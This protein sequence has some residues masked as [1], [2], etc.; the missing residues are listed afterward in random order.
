MISASNTN[1]SGGY[2][3]SNGI[4]KQYLIPGFDENGIWSSPDG[5]VIFD[6]AEEDLTDEMTIHIT[7]LGNDVEFKIEKMKGDN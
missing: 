2:S 1:W 6:I 5:G 4:L 7:Y 3:I